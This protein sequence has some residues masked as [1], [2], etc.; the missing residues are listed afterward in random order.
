MQSLGSGVDTLD[1]RKPEGVG[2]EA[3][4]SRK[5]KRR[6]ST[7]LVYGVS[8][9]IGFLLIAEMVSRLG[10]VDEKYLP[11]AS[12]VIVRALQLIVD[13]V[14]LQEVGWTLW[15][16]ALSLVLAA[17]IAIPAGVALASS[18]LAYAA[19]S[20][21]INALRPIPAVALIPLAILVWGQGTEMK[22]ML[23]TFGIIWPVLFNTIYGVRDV[24]PVV[25]ETARSFG[26]PRFAILKEVV[27]P[28][29]APFILTGI[30]IAASL[31]LVIIVGAELVAGATSGIG[32]FILQASSAGDDVA[33]VLAGAIW[34]GVLG[35]AINGILSLVDRRFFRWV[36]RG[37]EN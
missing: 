1:R 31:G 7:K 20:S 34:A 33:T 13:P 36:R 22:V 3:S 5:G 19:S 2:S 29:A 8:G 27:L 18:K 25:K 15:G 11:H 17:V 30:R 21:V 12:T 28:S 35:L 4:S 24:D 16:W 10:I 23:T 6:I 14:F 37:T 9:A 26:I 32:S